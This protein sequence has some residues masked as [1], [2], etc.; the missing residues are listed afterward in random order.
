[1]DRGLSIAERDSWSRSRNTRHR[2][3]TTRIYVACPFEGDIGGRNKTP[4]TRY[5]PGFLHL[6]CS[7]IPRAVGRKVITRLCHKPSITED[8]T[9][10]ATFRQP[11]LT[12]S[13]LSLLCVRSFIRCITIITLI[14]TADKSHGEHREALSDEALLSAFPRHVGNEP[15]VA[16]NC[17]YVDRGCSV[18]FTESRAD[19]YLE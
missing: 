5:H 1:M 3:S 12:L 9:A 15:V 6:R 18:Q 8:G 17:A 13:A 10:R 19:R 16:T 2:L 14:Y 11:R 7:P 4:Y